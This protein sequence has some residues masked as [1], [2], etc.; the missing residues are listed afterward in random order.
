MGIRMGVYVLG[1]RLGETPYNMQP[2]MRKDTT[3]TRRYENG[4]AAVNVYSNYSPCIYSDLSH[5][6]PLVLLQSNAPTSQPLYCVTFLLD[7]APATLGTVDDKHKSDFNIENRLGRD[8]YCN[9]VH[10]LRA[11]TI[12]LLRE[13]PPTSFHCPIF[14]QVLVMINSLG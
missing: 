7:S 3:S 4:W 13:A 8:V 14:P 6:K 2:W 10:N 5:L 12:S 1:R 11:L 9:D